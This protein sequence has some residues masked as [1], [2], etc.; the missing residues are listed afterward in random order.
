MFASPQIYVLNLVPSG[1]MFGDGDFGRLLNHDDK[2]LMN[3]ISTLIK[4]F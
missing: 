1:M 2:A 3:G 4:K